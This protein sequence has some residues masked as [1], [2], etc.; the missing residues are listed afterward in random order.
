[1]D[2]VFWRLERKVSDEQILVTGTSVVNFVDCAL[3]LA[4]D[5]NSCRTWL[6][7]SVIAYKIFAQCLHVPGLK[8]SRIHRSA[9]H[10]NLSEGAE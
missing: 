5:R 8:V 9:R 4:T 7:R 3:S 2:S 1:M 6:E 10:H